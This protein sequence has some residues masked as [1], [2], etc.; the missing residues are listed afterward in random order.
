MNELLA[1]GRDCLFIKISNKSDSIHGVTLTVVTMRVVRFLGEDR[2]N[3]RCEMTDLATELSSLSSWDTSVS[4]QFSVYLRHSLCAQ[5]VL[6]SHPVPLDIYQPATAVLH[7]IDKILRGPSTLVKDGG[8]LC[9]GIIYTY[10]CI[11][12]IQNIFAVKT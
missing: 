3:G 9:H 12:L 11:K 7:N 4:S 1:S 2:T 10:I 5:P 8:E 6:A